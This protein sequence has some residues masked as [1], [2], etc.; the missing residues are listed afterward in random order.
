MSYIRSKIKGI[1][2]I[3]FW[4]TKE[5]IIKILIDDI[6]IQFDKKKLIKDTKSDGLMKLFIVDKT[7]E[8][9]STEES[10]I[11]F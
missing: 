5:K 11:P 10:S 7:E 1:V 4:G 2:S 6:I 3:L 9:T 8:V